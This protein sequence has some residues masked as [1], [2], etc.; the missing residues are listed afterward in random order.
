MTKEKTKITIH[1]KGEREL[2]IKKAVLVET[3]GGRIHVEWDSEGAV[4]PLGQLPFFVEFLKTAELFEPWITECP[5]EYESPNAPS[6]RDI[7][8]T[9][10]LSVLGGHRRYAHISAI[11]ADGVNPELLGMKKTASE[12]SVRR[13]F[14]DADEGRC[15]RWQSDHLTRC[16]AALLCEPWILDID[17]TVKPLYGHQE[18]AVVGFNP[19]KPG[20][21]SH[22]YHTYLMANTRLVLDVEVQAGNRT[23]SKYSRPGL[24]AFLDS[25]DRSLWPEFLRGDCGFGNEDTIRE[26]E[27]RGL[28]YLFKLRQTRKVRRLLE[29]MFTEGEWE[30]AGG[31]Y[32]GVE[33]KLKLTG[34]TRERRV[35]ILRREIRDEVAMKNVS[36]GQ[37]EL[38]F[39][40]TLETVRTYEYVVLVTSLRD[41]ILSIAQHY[42]DRADA[43]NAFDELKNQWG[44]NGFTTKDLKRCRIMARN[45]ALIYNWWSLF[46]RLAVPHKHAEAITSRPLLLHAVAKQTSHA[47]Q[48]HLTIT[49]THAKASSVQRI[50]RSLV[51]F[52]RS[53][54]KSAE[55]LNWQ[56]RWRIILSR[57]FVHFL[58]GRLLR[59]QKLLSFSP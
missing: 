38:M 57:I 4:T 6:K 17:T 20:R 40:E 59:T 26:S 54:R 53:V 48:T 27:E 36:N 37:Q 29:K 33:A 14:K 49:S 55:Q 15:G 51:S 23:A 35:I 3:F 2:R 56:E 1:P 45:V 28:P 13:A 16:Y 7:L 24:F 18:G 42:R 21:P 44:W 11:R 32:E 12:D 39:I 41:G 43:E 52:F 10:L 22:V 8:G 34:W 50:L 30:P 25:L 31:G 9:I 19:R 58:G 46:V 5:L 47:G